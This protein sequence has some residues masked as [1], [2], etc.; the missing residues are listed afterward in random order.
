[1]AWLLWLG[2]FRSGRSRSVGNSLVRNRS[3]CKRSA[4]ARRTSISPYTGGRPMQS[5]KRRCGAKVRNA[6]GDNTTCR[7]WPVRGSSRW[8]MHGGGSEQYGVANPAFRTGK[9]AKLPARLPESFQ[10]AAADPDLLGLREDI[11]VND[12]RIAELAERLYSGESGALWRELRTA[13]QQ[14]DEARRAGQR[15]KDQ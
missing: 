4:G 9:Y 12:A 1:M 3:G 7:A 11:A 14:A 6:R 10:A 13:Q 5:D 15:A 2:A 8:R